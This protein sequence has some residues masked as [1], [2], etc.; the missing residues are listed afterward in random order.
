MRRQGVLNRLAEVMFVLVLR[1]HLQQAQSVTGFLAAFKDE[2]I[3][4]ALEA[5][6][7]A[8]GQGW[9]V[10]TLAREAR[11]SRTV[12]AE[13][14]ATL[15]GQTPMQ[16]LAGWRMHLAHEMLRAPHASVAQ[17]AEQLGYQDRD[18]ISAGVQTGARL[19]ARR[20]AAPS[21]Q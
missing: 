16:Y 14:F 2:R 6:H 15:L 19:R 12:F 11:M 5:L 9:R 4:R 1:H 20:C 18:C 17:V 8:P 13:R 21:A 10:E 3:G 7:R